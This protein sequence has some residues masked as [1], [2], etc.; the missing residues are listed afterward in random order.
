LLTSRARNVIG[1]DV[2]VLT[3]RAANTRHCSLQAIGAD[4]RHLPFATGY[5]DVIISNSTL[6]H[7]E[8]Q[9]DIIKSI[10]ELHRVLKRG[11]HLLITLDNLAN[12]IIGLRNILPFPLLSRLGLVPYYVGAS[13]GPYRLRRILRDVGF[14]IIQVQ[15]VMHCPRIFAVIIARFLAKYTGDKTHKKFLRILLA[16]ERLGIFPTRFLTGNFI[17]VK[18]MKTQLT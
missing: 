11:G 14:E 5:F 3:L 16:F 10:E 6:D 13:L 12:P 8:T 18:A 4:V 2:S 1:I 15:A 17:A 7:F 9:D